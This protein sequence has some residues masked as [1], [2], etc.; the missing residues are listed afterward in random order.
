[1]YLIHVETQ[2]LVWFNEVNDDQRYAILSHT[3]IDGSEV[4]FQ[5]W[6]DNLMVST[7]EKS[8]YPK[9][10][11][12][13]EK[14]KQDGLAYVWVDT[15]CIDKSSS[16]ELSEAINSMFKWYEGA[17]VCYAYLSDVPGLA[18]AELSLSASRWVT[19]GWTLQELIAPN[20]MEFFAADWSHIGSKE[21]LCDQIAVSCNIQKEYLNGTRDFRT[22]SIAKRM[23]WVAS[24]KTTRIEDMA[25]C[26][27]GI[28]DINMP[29]IYGEGKKSFRRLQEEIIKLYPEDHSIYA[30]G[31][32]KKSSD[33]SLN[34]AQATE[35]V[36]AR[37]RAYKDLITEPL[38]GLLA[39]SPKQFL[40]SGDVVPVPWI[41][42][43]YRTW[44]KGRPMA[45][46][47]VSI[48]KSIK[49]DLPVTRI[50]RWSKYRWDNFA[51]DQHRRALESVLLCTTSNSKR[52][53]HLPLISWGDGYFGRIRELTT[54]DGINM[55]KEDPFPLLKLYQSLHICA[56]R[57]PPVRPQIYD[58]V[59]RE[60]EVFERKELSL[61]S[62]VTNDGVDLEQEWVAR[63]HGRLE[64]EFLAYNF[65]YGSLAPEGFSV[66]LGRS[67]QNSNDL[68]DFHIFIAQWKPPF[69]GIV[70]NSKREERHLLNSG[71]G[72]QTIPSPFP[73][74]KIQAQL[75]RVVKPN[76]DKMKDC[77][78]DV[79]D[80][81]VKEDSMDSQTAGANV[82]HVTGT[83]QTTLEDDLQP[84]THDDD[85]QPSARDR[86]KSK[87]SFK[88]K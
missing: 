72:L 36:R 44:Q 70:W 82:I 6:R 9:I 39:E 49:I 57:T 40:N 11:G 55:E 5:E 48:G 88:S 45:T 65:T 84:S 54:D 77:F 59:I 14:A 51:E 86:W 47:A 83:I 8:G 63:V 80:L 87:L 28:F 64:M 26:L 1:M 25:Y 23:S 60:L 42:R 24:R 74:V 20:K 4:S 27:L 76:C 73:N 41:G 22:A 21:T 35:Q 66:V 33:V 85:V 62:C 31:L 2:K 71:L 29:M 12:C 3:W 37:H 81:H 34:T 13:C 43:F 19:R 7:K 38:L 79:I 61:W 10:M 56:E 58:V 30:W 18:G 52:L 15:C 67:H 53:I 78:I 69:R 75:D 17:A 46:P 32:P 16:A 68:P 50:K